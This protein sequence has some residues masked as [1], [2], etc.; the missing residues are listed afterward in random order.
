M[1]FE[2]TA[3]AAPGRR[4]D[5]E[6]FPVSIGTGTGEGQPDRIVYVLDDESD[7]RRSL[8]FFLK[9]AGFLPRPFLSG[10]DFMAE[11]CRLSPGCALIDVRMP[12]IDGLEVIEELTRR[13]F[14]LPMIVMTGHGDI[15]TAVRAMKLG[16][17]DFLE[18]PFEDGVL[19]EGPSA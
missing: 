8:G 9:T 14:R 12:D 13:H 1:E 6:D 17:I 11:A 18:K 3:Q 7:V 5:M 16:A 4:E 2:V 15:A 10:R 19:V